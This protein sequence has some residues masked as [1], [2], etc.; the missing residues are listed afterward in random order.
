[1]IPVTPS[2]DHSA[3]TVTKTTAVLCIMYEAQV[4][5]TTEPGTEYVLSYSDKC[6]CLSE[7]L[8]RIES[9]GGLHLRPCAQLG[10]VEY[11]RLGRRSRLP[12]SVHINERYEYIVDQLAKILF[13][14]KLYSD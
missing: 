2:T 6:H 5:L 14:M 1:M 8:S 9:R 4:I 11:S 7:Q 13:V 12:Y 3:M 10:R